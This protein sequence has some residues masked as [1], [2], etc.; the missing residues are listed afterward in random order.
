MSAENLS[1]YERWA[2]VG[3]AGGA[4]TVMELGGKGEGDAVR[5]LGASGR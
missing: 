4:Q 3:G 2:G 5:L 1:L